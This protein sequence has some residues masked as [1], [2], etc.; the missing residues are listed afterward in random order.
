[1]TRTLHSRSLPG[2]RLVLAGLLAVTLVAC[3]RRAP[4][5]TGSPAPPTEGTQRAAGGALTFDA[6]PL[7]RRMGMIARGAPFPVLGRTGFLASGTPDTTHVVVALTFPS[8]ALLFARE[9]DDRFRASYDVT[10]RIGQGTEVVARADAEEEV[11]VGSY[12][13]TTRTDESIIFQELLDVPPGK[14]T[15]LVTLRDRGSRRSVEE[16]LDLEVPRLGAQ[17][18]STPLPVTEVIARANRAALPN[19]LLAPAGTAVLGRDSVVPLYVESY[20]GS[21]APVRFF[22]RSES[23]RLLWTDT[24]ALTARDGID[25]GIVAVPV[26]RIGFGVARLTMVREGGSDSVVAS[27]F[28]GLGGDLPVTTFDDM[29]SFLR[30]YASPTRLEKLRNSAE[31]DRPVLWT[32][33]MRD[34]D[35]S[36]ETAEHEDLRAYF[37]RLAR[38]NGRFREE[39]TP[40]WLSDRGRVFISLGEPDQLIEPVGREFERNRQQVW[41]YRTIN[42]QL[43]FYDQTGAGRWRL[44]QSSE[45]RFEGEFRRRLR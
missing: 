21:G 36:P 1:M 27:V 19:L 15:L 3:A 2:G 39:A 11:I 31:T 9:A 35:T 41:D 44:T 10:I 5:A 4:T 42:L 6:T 34:T 45:A 23:G 40:G 33:F 25:A 7:Y 38:A 37:A 32:E 20:G 30:F 8:T 12:R 16:R 24:V 13:E 22:V 26:A 29:L 17:A 14:Y 43:V 18:L 28:T